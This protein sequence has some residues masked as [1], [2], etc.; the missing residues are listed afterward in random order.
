MLLLHDTLV[1]SSQLKATH[2][3][4]LWICHSVPA[5]S[6]RRRLSCC[7]WFWYDCC[8]PACQLAYQTDDTKL[9]AGVL[10]TPVES[11]SYTECHTQ[12]RGKQA[13][14]QKPPIRSTNR[15][16]G[17]PANRRNHPPNHR[18]PIGLAGN[19]HKQQHDAFRSV[20]A[21]NVRQQHQQ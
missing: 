1:L 15:P 16:T 7:Y 21:N 14:Q 6:K 17:R 19:H 2:T 13:S 20:R 10:P 12:L 8:M 5:A 9:S 3:I 18:P 4:S 11:S